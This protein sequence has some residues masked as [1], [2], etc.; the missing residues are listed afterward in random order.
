MTSCPSSARS[1]GFICS[2]ISLVA[3]FFLPST[4]VWTLSCTRLA[5]S[6][7]VLSL[8]NRH[9]PT[10]NALPVMVMP[11]MPVPAGQPVN[12][13]L[14]PSAGISVFASVGQSTCVPASRLVMGA[15]RR[16]STS[17]G[18]S[19]GLPSVP[20]VRLTNLNVTVNFIV[21]LSGS[22]TKFHSATVTIFPFCTVAVLPTG[23]PANTH[24]PPSTSTSVF[25][26]V[27]CV[28]TCPS[29]RP[30]IASGIKSMTS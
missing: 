7:G 19:L 21:G 23:H 18:S 20:L 27:G 1:T 29:V 17:C 13:H 22:S 26:G 4:R 8:S 14:P 16:S 5:T 6:T 25:A 28:M 10:T 30:S 9:P 2:S 12:T 15:G 24:L 3:K 11:V